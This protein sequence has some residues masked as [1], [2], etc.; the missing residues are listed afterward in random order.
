MRTS[1]FRVAALCAL[2]SLAIG[3]GGSPGG[4]LSGSSDD[5][6]V[7]GQTGDGAGPSPDAGPDAVPEDAPAAQPEASS[8]GTVEGSTDAGPDSTVEDAP[9]E[10]PGTSVEAGQDS[11]LQDSSSGSSDAPT[12]STLQGDAPADGSAP[13]SGDAGADAD[14]APY[15]FPQPA[16]PNI[17]VDQ[18]GY[19][20]TAEKIAVIRNPLSGFDKTTTPFVPGATYALVDATSMAKVLEAAPT[21]WN[22]GATDPTSGDQAWWFDF[23]SVTTPGTYYVLDETLNVQSDTFS[24][25]D[26]VYAG[27]L[28]QATRM[29]YYQRDGIAKDAAYAGTSW[30]D[31]MEHPQNATCGLYD[32]ASTPKDLHGGWDD[33][34]DENKYSLFAATTA[35]SLLRAYAENPGAFG[36]AT[37]IPE[38]GNG[39][40]DVLDEAKWGIDWLLR[41]QNG[42]GSVLTIV[43]NAGASPPSADTSPCQYGPVSTTVTLSSAA[44]F[45]YASTV[46][47][48]VSAVATT[49]PGYTTALT[50][51]AEGA[52]TW[53]VANPSVVFYNVTNGLGYREQEVDA[54]G[55]LELEVQAAAFL[56]ELTGGTSYQSVVDTNYT[57]LQ[58]ALDP[59]T[60]WPT[61]A[62]LEYSIAPG[63]T[64]AVA[65][66]IQSTF[67]TAVEG[68]GFFGA[69][70]PSKD[71][72]LAYIDSYVLN[73]TGAKA[74][75]GTLLYD[76]ST[77]Q[78]DPTAEASATRYAERY[79][80]YL[81]GVN[82]MGLVYMSNMA[83]SGAARSVNSIFSTWF[84]FGTPWSRVGASTYGPPPGFLVPGPNTN[85]TWA[86]CCST[87][88]CGSPANNALCGGPAPP[89][90]PE[91]QPDQKTYR[92]FN[93]LY[94]LD[95]W[96]V[97]ESSDM[98]QAEY[99]R[100]V[101]KFV[102]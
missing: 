84:G 43:T 18:F 35:I 78:V 23:S 3:C 89:A 46:L 50:T 9:E 36:D 72:Y 13:D 12:D 33:A 15:L 5:G 2:G 27:V 96:L 56:F 28:Q 54:A 52:W 16:A 65:Q 17:V 21:A 45:A 81:H 25:A 66:S 14:A 71:P 74:G 82:P 22:T 64:T 37:G 39:V 86:A 87:A 53:T 60:L 76:V 4:S 41:M 26:G 101:S 90:P 47:Q 92:D 91:N 95:T 79:V 67:Q 94:P 57:S 98:P 32:D 6:A 49:Y 62:L 55:R 99:V 58:T 24:I 73:S 40:P 20:T 68:A 69:A 48:S 34:S 51:A 10:S 80:H 102:N 30:S 11:T 59:Y 8:D 38:S 100:L 7:D 42:D 88:A 93:N 75:Q 70:S 44:V 31:G 29:L 63:A 1:S 97:G 61:E 19:R 83:G 77:F 85:Y